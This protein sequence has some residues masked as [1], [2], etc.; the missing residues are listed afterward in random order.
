MYGRDRIR[1]LVDATIPS[2]TFVASTW[3]PYLYHE[4]RL[5]SGSH[6]GFDT[7]GRQQGAIGVFVIH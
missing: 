5:A 1:R 6:A 4:G 7:F 3:L 2:W